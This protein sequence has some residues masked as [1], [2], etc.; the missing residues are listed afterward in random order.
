MERN[1]KKD[2]LSK[3]KKKKEFGILEYLWGIFMSLFIKEKE[4]K[5][6]DVEKRAI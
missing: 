5:D 2:Q 4:Q 6:V 1:L 3:K